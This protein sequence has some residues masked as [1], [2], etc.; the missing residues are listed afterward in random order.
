M[1]D[2]TNDDI[3]LDIWLELSDML[4]Q[5]LIEKFVVKGNLRFP[6]SFPKDS[7]KQ[8]FS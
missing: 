5:N 2:V 8:H 4:S 3:E 7:Q 6:N 1:S